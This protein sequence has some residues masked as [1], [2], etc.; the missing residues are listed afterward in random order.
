MPWSDPPF[1]DE[2]AAETGRVEQCLGFADS[3]PHPHRF[4][5]WPGGLLRPDPSTLVDQLLDASQ[6][7]ELGLRAHRVRFGKLI[8]RHV[9]GDVLRT[10]RL[11]IVL[12]ALVG[13]V[14]PQPVPSRAH[15]QFGRSGDAV[16]DHEERTRPKA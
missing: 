11:Q 1:G 2:E 12:A 10:G 3:T 7:Q 15:R 6:L 9:G 13:A 14:R 4:Q 16:V 5:A 8:E